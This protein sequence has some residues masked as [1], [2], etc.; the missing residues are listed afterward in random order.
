M[1]APILL[2]DHFYASPVRMV[3][4]QLLG[5]A[6]LIGFTAQI[7]SPVVNK[8]SAAERLRQQLLLIGCWI[9]AVFVGALGDGHTLVFYHD[10]SSTVALPAYLPALQGRVS[11]GGSSEPRP[12]AS[13][14]MASLNPCG[15]LTQKASMPLASVSYTLQPSIRCRTPKKFSV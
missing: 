12:G 15:L 8:A 9:E 14:G 10:G 1:V 11:R 13:V 7:Q 3:A 4:D 2:G 6:P 5:G